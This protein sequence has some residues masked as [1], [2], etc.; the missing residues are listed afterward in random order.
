MRIKNATIF[1]INPKAKLTLEH[2][3]GHM[4]TPIGELALESSGWVPVFEGSPFFA[5]PGHALLMFMQE[6]KHIPSSAVDVKL[7][8][9]CADMEK[10]LGF[11]PGKKQRKDLKEDIVDELLPRALATRRRTAVWIDRVKHRLV[12]DSTSQPVIDAVTKALVKMFDDLGVQDVSWPRTAVVTEWLIREPVGF[13]LD[14]E[15]ALAYPGEHGK[16]VAFK[17]SDLGADDVQLHIQ[18]HGASVDTVAMTFD[19][20]ISFV[21]TDRAQLRRIKMLDVITSAAPA[22]DVDRFE[23]EFLLTVLEVGNLIDALIAEA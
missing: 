11:A 7:E 10:A 14:D 3:E 5:T 12:I 17:A 18:K 2:F 13:T 20:R 9:R 16:T 19:S 23:S 15:V 1:G 4:F 6:K 8:E 22:P 21:M